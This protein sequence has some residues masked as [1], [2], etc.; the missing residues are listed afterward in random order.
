MLGV[1]PGKRRG[2][3][4]S[5]SVGVAW[6]ASSG[7]NC[8]EA[9]STPVCSCLSTQQPR[10]GQWPCGWLVSTT[11]RRFLWVTRKRDQRQPKNIRSK[12]II[13]IKETEEPSGKSVKTTFF[14]LEIYK[15]DRID[16]N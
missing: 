8:L 12:E 11:G 2:P 16:K 6:D 1:R 14:L 10:P 3:G 13:T 15:I 7:R 9:S 5:C 4:H